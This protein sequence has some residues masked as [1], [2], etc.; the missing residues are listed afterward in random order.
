MDSHYEIG[1]LFYLAAQEARSAI[2]GAPGIAPAQMWADMLKMSP[3][4]C[5]HWQAAAEA[6]LDRYLD[7]IGVF[8]PKKST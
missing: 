2:H 7:S 6:F 4:A 5:A 3:Q 1:R 8:P